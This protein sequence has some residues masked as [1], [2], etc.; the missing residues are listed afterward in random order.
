MTAGQKAE[1]SLIVRP[2]GRKKLAWIPEG[3]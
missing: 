1:I 2:D 3:E